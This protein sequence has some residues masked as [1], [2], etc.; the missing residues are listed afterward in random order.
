MDLELYAARASP[1]GDFVGPPGKLGRQ[2]ETWCLRQVDSEP[3]RISPNQLIIP[4]I[5]NFLRTSTPSLKRYTA[6]QILGIT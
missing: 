3:Q 1:R 2:S 4:S 5:H 6:G